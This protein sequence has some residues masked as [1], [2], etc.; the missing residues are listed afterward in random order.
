[1]TTTIDADT[2]A[3]ERMTHS[4]THSTEAEAE[5]EERWRDRSVGANK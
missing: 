4:L 1:M 2:A 5:A 3:Q